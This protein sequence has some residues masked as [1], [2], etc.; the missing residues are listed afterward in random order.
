[1]IVTF[2]GIYVGEFFLPTEINMFDTFLKMDQFTKGVAFIETSSKITNL[3]RYWPKTGLFEL[4][5]WS[6]FFKFNINIFNRTASYTLYA[7]CLHETKFV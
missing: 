4:F 1:M 3:G 5:I 2:L 7:R 6:I